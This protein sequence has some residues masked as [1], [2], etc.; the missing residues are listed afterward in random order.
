ME[1]NHLKSYRSTPRLDSQ[2]VKKLGKIFL[3]EKMNFDLDL[4]LFW[5]HVSKPD[6]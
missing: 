2:F 1:I 3:E 4:G 5:Q 6:S